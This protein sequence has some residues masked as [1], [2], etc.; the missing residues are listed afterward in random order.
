MT[1]R[2]E[3]GKAGKKTRWTEQHSEKEKV[4]GKR[5]EKRRRRAREEESERWGRERV[6]KTVRGGVS[7]GDIFTKLKA[8]GGK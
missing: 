4:R 2:R 6:E 1:K 8:N 5:Q 3:T 7:A